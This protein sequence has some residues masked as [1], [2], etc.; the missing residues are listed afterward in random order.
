M[1][2]DATD[3][4]PDT[5]RA[6]PEA[7]CQNCG[8]PLVGDYC[9]GC[10]Q[11][12]V[13]VLRVRTLARLFVESVLELEDLEQGVGQT[14]V[15]AA[16]NPGRLARRYADGERKRFINPIGYFLMAATFT[17][18][19]LLL[20]KEAWI[21]GQTEMLL[22]AWGS[23]GVEPAVLFG[24]EGAYRSALGVTSPQE[25]V[26]WMF[27]WIQQL[28]TY[29]GLLTSVVASLFLWGLFSDSSVAETFVFE[30]YVTAQATVW[31]GLLAP[32]FFAFAP[33][34]IGVAGPLLQIGLHAHGGGA[35]FEG[36]WKARLLP[37]FAYLTGMIVLTVSSA[38]IAIFLL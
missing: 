15:Q 20:F 34:L 2:E 9:H 19:V 24:P 25:L 8:T 10:G 22:A 31:M 37:V 4:P 11:R 1:S 3:D 26:R 17:F 16:R 30:L 7:V 38:L 21:Q 18:L 5:G 13:P 29:T 33:V 36:R 32:L 6:A 27:G 28:Q 12:H 14:I 35:F 23:M